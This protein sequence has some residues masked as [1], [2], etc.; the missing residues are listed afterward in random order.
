MK[1][2]LFAVIMIFLI[3]S[4]AHAQEDSSRSE[5]FE[6]MRGKVLEHI[7]NKRGLLDAFESCVQSTNTREDMKSCRKTH[8]GKMDALR[9]ER[10]HR[11]D[12]RR[13]RQN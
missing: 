3:Q 10:K 13:N 12:K 9:S 4:A 7:N 11:K 6:K 8:K 1:R 5:K 2:I